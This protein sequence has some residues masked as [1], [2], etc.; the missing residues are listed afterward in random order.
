MADN[1]NP[2]IIA[3]QVKAPA[4]A[5]MVVA[6]LSIAGGLISILVN[7][8]GL[9]VG[10]AQGSEKF[11]Q[12]ASGAAGISIAVLCIIFGVVILLGAIKMK[13]LESRGFAMTAAI[14]AVIPCMTCCCIGLPVGIWA[15]V[16][17]NK[18]EVKSAF[19]G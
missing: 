13:N 18:P 10:Q 15:L 2:S 6:G 3:E 9:A 5:L 8:L 17:L 1:T 14:L 19:P 12:M 4:I 16:I 7:V 11:G